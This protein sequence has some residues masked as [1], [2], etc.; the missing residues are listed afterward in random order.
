MCWVIQHILTD[1]DYE[2]QN[3][4]WGWRKGAALKDRRRIGLEGAVSTVGVERSPGDSL[5]WFGPLS[6]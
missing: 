4:W 2:N 6:G 1:R 3:Q 5:V